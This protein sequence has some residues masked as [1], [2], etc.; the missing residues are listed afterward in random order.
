MHILSCFPLGQS[1]YPAAKAVTFIDPNDA[2]E[3]AAGIQA[4]QI[5]GW[6]FGIRQHVAAGLFPQLQFSLP[7]DFFQD[8]RTVSSDSQRMLSSAITSSSWEPALL[9]K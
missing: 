2:L 6:P 1:H 9:P 7:E 4:R 3:A 5:K 8:S